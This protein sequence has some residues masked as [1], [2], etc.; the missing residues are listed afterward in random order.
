MGEKVIIS[1]RIKNQGKIRQGY[2]IA[3]RETGLI[4]DISFDTKYE[5]SFEGESYYYNEDY[6]IEAGDF[7]GH[8]HPEQSLYT[9]IVDKSWD[10]GTWCR[11]TIYKYSTELKP[12]HIYLGC[13]RAFSRMLA[14]GVTS[15]MVSFYCHNNRGNEYDKEVIRAAE[16]TG[17]RLYFGRMTYDIINYDAYEAKQNS[18]R[19][20]FETPEEGKENFT[21]LYKEIDSKR[22]TVAPS[23]HSIHAS[24]KEAIITAIN[25]GNKYDRYVQFH[26]SEDQGDVDLS[27]KLYGLRPIE[28]LSSL[29]ECGQV[30]S[31]ER[32]ILSDCVWIDE[33]ERELIKKHN[34]KV[35]L[36]PRMNDRVKAGQ[37]E[38]LKFISMGIFPYL[39]TDGEASNDDLSV[40][41]ERQYLKQKYGKELGT[42]IDNLGKEPLKLGEGFVA[43]LEVGSFCD[44]K[45]IKG[46]EV[47]DVFVGGDQVI[48][49]GELIAMDVINEIER[50]LIEAM[51]RIY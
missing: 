23:V 6:V 16:D 13:C 12:E 22:V 51:R 40:T 28:F 2:I 44:I 7:N 25:L 3:N 26:L 1:G 34:M 49:N 17:I 18:Q 42:A 45:V 31:L 20:Y 21:Q 48:K 15:V 32:I 11:N 4:T 46:N 36:N 35:V 43:S 9:D 14:L 24:T 33:K 8:S 38:L 29:V 47:V 41:G 37:A 19:C 30:E 5:G 50:P 39:G 27:L 10:L